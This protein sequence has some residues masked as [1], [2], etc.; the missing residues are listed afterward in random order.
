LRV[1]FG[2]NRVGR[3]R[4]GSGLDIMRPRLVRFPS[5]SGPMY[6][7]PRG[8]A[9]IAGLVAAILCLVLTPVQSRAWNG[10]DSPPLVRAVDPLVDFLFDL[11]LRIAPSVDNY[12]FFGRFFFLVYLLALA[13]LWAFHARSRGHADPPEQRWFRVLAG[14]LGVEAVADTGPYWGGLES[15]F[16]VLFLLEELA[17]LLILVGTAFYGRALLRS[18]SAPHGWGGYSYWPALGR[19]P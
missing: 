8:F 10:A 3:G 4:D 16:A 1:V 14:G 13:G 11:R 6:S 15:P 17:L 18:R 19:S 2:I 7:L 5:G 9:A 12:H